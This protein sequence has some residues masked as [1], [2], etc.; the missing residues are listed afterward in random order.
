MTRFARIV[1]TGSALP[2][3]IVSNAELAAQMAERGLETSDDWIVAR[4]GIR[5]RRIAADVRFRR[6]RQ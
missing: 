4:T 1:G 3:R 2:E 5:E 6:T